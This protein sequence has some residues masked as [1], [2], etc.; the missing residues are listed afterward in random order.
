MRGNGRRDHD[1]GALGPGLFVFFAMMFLGQWLDFF[2]VFFVLSFP[3][4]FATWWLL[5]RGAGA[6]LPTQTP[7]TPYRPPRP[8]IPR[9]VKEA[10]YDRDGGRC[11][12]CGSAHKIHFDHII[13]FS[14]GGSDSEENLQILCQSCNLR[15][16]AN[17]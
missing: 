17:L 14:K 13:P 1:Y 10:V 3:A 16:G 15:K 4:M 7:P 8:P 6:P 12:Q 2:F 5:S 9:A 11:V